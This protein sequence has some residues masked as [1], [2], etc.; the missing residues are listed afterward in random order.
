M[1]DSTLSPA[2]RA[3]LRRIAGIMVP[4]SAEFGVPGADDPTIFT[5]IEKSLGRDFPAVRAALADLAAR[6]GA[7]FA[8]LPEDRAN[9]VAGAFLAQENP[10]M[11]TLGRAIL[12]CYYRDDRV[13]I[14]LGLEARPPFPKGRQIEQG[15]WSL[16]DKV[17]TRPPMWRKA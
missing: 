7:S 5:D 14:A 10:N 11:T 16:L 9:A 4:A 3:D 17:R 2:E 6:A 8:A 1:P 15:D 12:Q 13:M